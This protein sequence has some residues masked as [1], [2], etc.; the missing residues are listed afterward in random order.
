MKS[1][2]CLRVDQSS[3]LRGESTVGGGTASIILIYLV[4]CD[5]IN[6]HV[7]NNFHVCTWSQKASE[8]VSEVVNFKNFLGGGG[9]APRPP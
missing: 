4:E 2:Q 9:H 8:T 1:F 6:V 7:Y 3:Y 5:K